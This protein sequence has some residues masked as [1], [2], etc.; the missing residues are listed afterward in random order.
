MHQKFLKFVYGGKLYQFASLPNVLCSGP[1]NFTKLL[2]P[3]LASLRWQHCLVSGYIDDL[4][5]INI[6]FSSCSDNI[7]LCASS[8]SSLGFVIHTDNSEFFP[9]Q[10]IEYQG[11]VINSTD[12]NVRLTVE[13]NEYILAWYL[14]VFS[15]LYHTIPEV[16]QLLGKFSSSLTGV[17]FGLLHCLEQDKINYL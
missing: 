5:T 9:S 1:R 8:P 7:T 17:K 3:S 14:N 16:T 13:E 6:T 12:M 4:I 10:V 2:K 15:A 11:F